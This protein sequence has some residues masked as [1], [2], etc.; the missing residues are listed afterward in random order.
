MPA[1]RI[2]PQTNMPNAPALCRK[3][4][5]A[6]LLLHRAAKTCKTHPMAPGENGIPI[7]KIRGVVLKFK[8]G[9][10]FYAYRWPGK[11]AGLKDIYFI[12]KEVPHANI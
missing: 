10:H 9:R 8:F 5:V 11:T 7:D 2:P 1:A 3:C 12:C 6:F 4:C